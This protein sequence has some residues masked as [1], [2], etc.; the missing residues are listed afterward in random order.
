MMRFTGLIGAVGWARE[1]N[2]GDG[3]VSTALS[4]HF[5]R[6]SAMEI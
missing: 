3:A 6:E 4:M 2:D 1:K 5:L